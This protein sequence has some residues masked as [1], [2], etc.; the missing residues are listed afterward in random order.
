MQPA[1]LAGAGRAVCVNTLGL[2]PWENMQVHKIKNTTNFSAMVQLRLTS[3]TVKPASRGPRP[4][5]GTR[6]VPVPRLACRASDEDVK[7]LFPENR[8]TV[9]QDFFK[10]KVH[11]TTTHTPG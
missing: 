5:K 7:Q 10:N 8:E 6:P 9:D 2:E 11:T 1:P 3:C 4:W